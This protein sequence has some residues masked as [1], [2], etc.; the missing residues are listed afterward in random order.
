MN[1]K[2]LIKKVSLWLCE[3]ILHY[4]VDDILE[5]YDYYHEKNCKFKKDDENDG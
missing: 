5:F 4:V 2:I 1:F 3:F